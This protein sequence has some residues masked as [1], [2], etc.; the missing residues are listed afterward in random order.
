MFGEKEAKH[1]ESYTT[2]ET[3]GKR[4]LTDII[5]EYKKEFGAD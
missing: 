4:Y 1:F 5:E 3:A 2:S